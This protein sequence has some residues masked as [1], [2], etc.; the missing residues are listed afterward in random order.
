MVPKSLG[1]LTGLSWHLQLLSWM[2]LSK[3]TCPALPEGVHHAVSL[4]GFLE[5]LDEIMCK[6][7]PQVST[8]IWRSG[9]T[10]ALLMGT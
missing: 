8:R 2:T 9:N 5:G 4:T 3:F 6:R 7:A 1:L 10:T